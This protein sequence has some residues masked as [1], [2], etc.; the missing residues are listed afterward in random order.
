M[1]NIEGNIVS[2]ETV[3]AGN[4]LSHSSTLRPEITSFPDNIG[5]LRTR[6]ATF[7]TLFHAWETIMPVAILFLWNVL[8]K[9]YGYGRRL[10]II[11]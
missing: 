11:A 3:D 2:L 5:S 8:I 10:A 9:V 7:F 4:I 1:R 6:R